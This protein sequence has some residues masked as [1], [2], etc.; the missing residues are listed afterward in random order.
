MNI[1]LTSG[2]PQDDAFDL[3]RW[4][5]D[6]RNW[7]LI[8]TVAATVGFIMRYITKKLTDLINNHIERSDKRQDEQLVKLDNA[9]MDIQNRIDLHTKEQD[10]TLLRIQLQLGIQ[11]KLLT[12]QEVLTLYDEYSRKGGNSYISRVVQEYLD[13]LDKGV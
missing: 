10:L 4:V 12:K 9:L 5:M 3:I 6:P 13:N 8:G 11:T 1:L 7:A 2:F